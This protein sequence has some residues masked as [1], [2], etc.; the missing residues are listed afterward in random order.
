MREM[1]E[2]KRRLRKTDFR[3]TASA[4]ACNFYNI[5]EYQRQP[6]ARILFKLNY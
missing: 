6:S 1:Q 3:R 4:S 5:N 2:S